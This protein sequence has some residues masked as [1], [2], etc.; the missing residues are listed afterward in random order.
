MSRRSPKK[1]PKGPGSPKEPPTPRVEFI[2]RADHG[3]MPRPTLPFCS[4][5]TTGVPPLRRQS[6]RYSRDAMEE[7]AKMKSAQEAK[8]NGASKAKR[9]TARLME[10]AQERERKHQEV[11]RRFPRAT[12]RVPRSHAAVSTD[13]RRTV[14]SFRVRQNKSGDLAPH[15][16]LRPLPRPVGGTARAAQQLL[17]IPR[18]LLHLLVGVMGRGRE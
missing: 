9:D 11:V 10:Q 3:D 5:D 8:K 17:P 18:A 12:C 1:A 6:Q 4:A 14:N 7:E 13:F 2:A 15:S 16:T